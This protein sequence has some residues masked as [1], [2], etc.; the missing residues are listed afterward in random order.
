MKSLAQMIKQ[1]SG[2]I[3][4][5]DATDWESD[6]LRSVVDRSGNGEYTPRITEK[7][8]EVIERIYK[9]HFA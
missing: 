5:K 1:C 3:G 7:Q 8:A 9:K 4:T 6:F 2:L